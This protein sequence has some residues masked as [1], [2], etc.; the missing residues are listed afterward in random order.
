MGQRHGDTAHV[1]GNVTAFIKQFGYE[2]KAL[3]QQNSLNL[4]THIDDEQFITN[5]DFDRLARVM[6]NLFANVIKYA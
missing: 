6:E 5:V 2:M 1:L 4:E 3:L